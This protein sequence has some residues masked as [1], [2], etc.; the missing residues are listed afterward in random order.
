[1]SAHET[2]STSEKR[3][4]KTKSKDSAS[5][6][7]N[8][9][10]NDGDDEEETTSNVPVFSHDVWSSQSFVQACSAARKN[11]PK[12]TCIVTQDLHGYGRYLGEAL[13]GNTHV[14]QLHLFLRPE[15]VGGEED[16]PFELYTCIQGP[17]RMLASVSKPLLKT[18]MWNT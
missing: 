7:D 6:N 13:Q 9:M 2:D 15:E 16:R 10:M 14:S 5:S 18:A 12:T 1:M 4:R 11:D 3:E 17:W 8:G